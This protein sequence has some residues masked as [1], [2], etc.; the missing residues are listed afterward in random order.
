MQPTD[1]TSGQGL[2]AT[3]P[4]AATRWNWGA[5]M[6]TVL[7]LRGNNLTGRD[8][9]A[10]LRWKGRLRARRI[11][12]YTLGAEA[13]ELAWRSR[14]WPSVQA[15]T[16]V[17]RRWNTAGLTALGLLSGVIVYLIGIFLYAVLVN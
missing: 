7:W 12:F 14:R 15:F 4:P 8:V 17:Q 9:D 11:L 10:F 6:F 13:N 5:F 1:N 16:S 3:A 2:N